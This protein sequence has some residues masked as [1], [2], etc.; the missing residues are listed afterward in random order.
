MYGSFVTGASGVPA[1]AN[2]IEAV[3]D[4]QT[5]DPTVPDW[6]RLLGSGSCRSGMSG[7]FDFGANV[8][9]L[10]PWAVPA[11]GG[12]AVSWTSG[13]KQVRIKVVAA[14]GGA[15]AAPLDANTE[16][17]GFKLSLLGAKTVGTGAC[18][19]CGV[20]ACIVLNQVKITTVGAASDKVYVTPA[21][22]SHVNWQ[23]LVGGCPGI[24]PTVNSSWGQVKSMYRQ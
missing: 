12:P 17:Y 13:P 9:C 24:T 7:N 23:A 22:R 19:G 6:W 20:A 15:D 10:A 3:L 1:P 2:G 14:V 21:Q 18:A 4:V 16:Y 11:T 8:V 5:A